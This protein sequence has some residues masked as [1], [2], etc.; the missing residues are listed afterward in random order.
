MKY[1][2]E[3]QVLEQYESIPKKGVSSTILNLREAGIHRFKELGF[4]KRKSEL[5][6]FL[7]FKGLSNHSFLYDSG[8]F[9]QMTEEDF[10]KHYSPE[11]KNYMVFLDGLYSESFSHLNGSSGLEIYSLNKEATK[12]SSS[13]SEDDLAQGLL[14]GLDQEEDVFSTLNLAFL[15][16]VCVLD[17]KSTPKEP[18]ELIFISS[19]QSHANSKRGLSAV[20][21]NGDASKLSR[22][23][24][25]LRVLVRVREGVSGE[26]LV[27]FLGSSS[28]YFLSGT[29]DFL[30]EPSASLKVVERQQEPSSIWHFLKLRGDLYEKSQFDYSASLWGSALLRHSYEFHLKG[31]ESFCSLKGVSVLTQEESAHSCIRIFHESPYAK[32]RQF[33]RNILTDRGHSSVDTLVCVMEGAVGTDSYQLINNLLLSDSAIADTKPNLM[34]YNDDVQCAHGATIGPINEDELFYLKSRGFSE[35]EAKKLLALGFISEVL[36]EV[37]PQRFRKIMLQSLLGKLEGRW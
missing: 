18:M 27:R 21:G 4:P 16:N 11:Y 17:I 25:P 9:L 6:R 3:E 1:S 7:D 29:I 15:Q 33:F 12:M 19:A 22:K 35:I 8:S 28:N 24:I 31:A 36:A 13:L 20:N 23:F 32:S 37:E 14:N 10:K 30:I 26:L 5:F 2:S 34:I